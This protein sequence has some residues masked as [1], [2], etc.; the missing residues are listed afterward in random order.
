VRKGIRGDAGLAVAHAVSHLPACISPPSPPLSRRA[1]HRYFGLTQPFG[2]ASGSILQYLTHEQALADYAGLIESFQQ[3]NSVAQP[4]IVFGGSYGGMLA[5]WGRQKYPSSFAGAI[6][7]SAPIFA[8]NRMGYANNSY[9][10]VVTADA[11]ATGGAAPACAANVKAAF[12]AL[13]AAASTPAGLANLSSTF[14]MCGPLQT[15][16]D[17]QALALFHLNAWDTMAMINYP[18]PSTYSGVLLPAWPVRTACEYLS[19]PGLATGDPWALLAAF[20]AAG[21]VFNNAT[22]NNACYQLPTDLFEDGIWDY[23]WC[24]E[25]VPEET[26]FTTTG[27]VS[28]VW[29]G[30]RGGGWGEGTRGFPT[31]PRPSLPRSLAPL[32]SP[33]VVPHSPLPVSSCSPTCSTRACT[34]RTP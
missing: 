4:V 33:P 26:F 21:N 20:E 34:T 23:V 31:P 12:A 17:I 28:W 9:W 25:L 6:A 24:T 27:T 13:F 10:Q 19:D 22:L 16:S 14:Q 15:P 32:S 7:G 1:E 30:G 29:L 5:T 2:T 11:T 8:F 18:Y 3:N